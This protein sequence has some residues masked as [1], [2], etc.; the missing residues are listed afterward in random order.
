VLSSAITSAA[1]PN[2]RF[3][4][5]LDEI[6]ALKNQPGKDIYLVGG[7]RTTANLIDAGVVDEL[8]MIVYPLIAGEGKSLF[9]S[10]TRQH[11]L[12]LK[13]VQELSEGRVSLVYQIG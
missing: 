2:T 8:R 5:S 11:G 9:A 1:W 6:V 10:A 3:I 7:A 4:Q 13:S 12:E